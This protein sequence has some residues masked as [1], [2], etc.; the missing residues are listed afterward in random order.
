MVLPLI[1]GA[2]LGLLGGARYLEMKQQEK[3]A[4]SMLNEFYSDVQNSPYAGTPQAMMLMRQ[5]EAAAAPSSFLDRQRDPTAQLEQMGGG[6]ARM[7]MDYYNQGQMAQQAR[8]AQEAQMR[9]QRENA[10][11]DRDLQRKWREEDRGVDL[12]QKQQERQ[13][14]RGW[15]IT[16]RNMQ[17]GNQLGM[18][19]HDDYRTA[20]G[21]FAQMQTGARNALGA[22]E[23]GDS[24]GAIEAVYG[25][26]KLLDPR[27]AVMEGD[28]GRFEGSGSVGSQV[29]NTLNKW[30]GEG[31]DKDT[32]KQMRDLI[33][34]RLKV[35]HGTWERT[36]TWYEQQAENMARQGVNVSSPIGSMG[37][38]PNYQPW[39]EEEK[40][41]AE[42]AARMQPAGAPYVGPELPFLDR[43]WNAA[44]GQ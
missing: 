33:L 43:V 14:D 25:I 7:S 15:E 28:A 9:W 16:D 20:A 18:A 35:Q 12:W 10:V 1:M 24:I 8:Q 42:E 23:S 17:M 40:R 13:Q 27:G 44:R 5:A 34:R 21:E 4:G 29:A 22:L 37:E 41:R 3:R 31:M 19:L 30:R 38:D 39:M 11:T 6:L 2:G 26:A 36:K 32:V